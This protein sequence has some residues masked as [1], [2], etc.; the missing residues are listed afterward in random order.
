[1]KRLLVLVLL[2]GLSGF[3]M[4]EEIGLE[5][6]SEVYFGDVADETVISLA[7]LLKYSKSI[8][9]LDI[10]LWVQYIMTF[11]DDTYQSL[12]VEPEL[13]YTLPMGPGS[14]A[15]ALYGEN[16][17]YI[18]PDDDM[19]GMIEPSVKYSQGFD[20]G[21]LFVKI[22]LPY[23]YEPDTATDLY[24]TLGYGKN[25]F[26][27]ELMGKYNIDPD[28]KRTGYEALFSYEADMYYA[29]VN[30]ESDKSFEVY[31]VSPYA[32]IYLGK[33]TAWAGIDFANIGGDGDVLV[34]PYI[35]GTYKF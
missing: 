24:G 5:V 21:D 13:T 35:G 27:V 1:M 10:N 16:T 26:G 23:T 6:G 20:F 2:V 28:G 7:P 4:A 30:I 14:L 29:E 18:D 8:D 31:T 9:A 33:I 17:F 22:G 3:V 11:D 12:Y 34:M 19:D 25:G 32:E 15:L